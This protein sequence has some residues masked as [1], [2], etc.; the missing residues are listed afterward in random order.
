[1]E[2]KFLQGE[3]LL[4]IVIEILVV[5]SHQLRVVQP[6]PVVIPHDDGVDCKDWGELVEVEH[7]IDCDLGGVK[8]SRALSGAECFLIEGLVGL[9]DA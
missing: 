9:Y 6:R 8:A 5:K 7:G 4:A 1:M 3:V 2:H